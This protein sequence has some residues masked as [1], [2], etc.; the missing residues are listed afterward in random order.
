[1]AAGNSLIN[2]G[3]IENAI[4]LAWFNTNNNNTST[5]LT[6]FEV[7][8][9]DYDYLTSQLKD[10]ILRLH[11]FLTINTLNVNDF[12][13]NIEYEEPFVADFNEYLNPLA[14]VTYYVGERAFRL[15]LKDNNNNFRTILESLWNNK[16]SLNSFNIKISPN[17]NRTRLYDSN[18]GYKNITRI[19]Y[20]VDINDYCEYN[21]LFVKAPPNSE[22]DARLDQLQIAHCGYNNNNNC[23]AVQFYDFYVKN[24][25]L[26]MNQSNEIVTK[27]KQAWIDQNNRHN[28]IQF[29]NSMKANLYSLTLY[30]ING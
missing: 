6:R 30:S 26:S 7:E 25:L 10:V 16:N 19:I 17:V 24:T 12:N 4:R 13:T 14:Q 8:I 22:I 5:S 2:K 27:V 11:Y 29:R 9:I 20:K 21:E 15:Y 28:D 1:M 3:A 23:T 18:D